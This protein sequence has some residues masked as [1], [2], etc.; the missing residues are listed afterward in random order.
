[1][2]AGYLK[3]EDNQEQKDALSQ[4]QKQGKELFQGQK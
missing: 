4:G 3:E 2:F 1:M